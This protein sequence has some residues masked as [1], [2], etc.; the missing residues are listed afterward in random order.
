MHQF[1]DRASGEV[2]DEDLFCDRLIAYLYGRTREQAPALFRALT[3]GRT[4]SLLGFLNYDLPLGAR[5]SSADRLARRLGIDLDECVRPRA[6][7][8]TA[9]RIFERQIRYETV[10]PMDESP[11]EVVSP[12]DSRMF[13]GA[14]EPGSVFF[15]KDKFFS[16]PELLGP[17][18]RDWLAAFKDGDFAVF[19]LTP[20]KYHYNHVPVGGVVR[21]IYTIEG[22]FHSCN[23]TAVI[24]E[25][26]PFS[27]NRRVVTILDTDV[28]GGAGCG[29]V[30][31]VEVVALMIG[32]IVQAYSDHDYDAPQSL[33]PGMFL[34]KGRPKSLYR[35]GSSLDVLIFQKGRVEFCPDLRRHQGRADVTNRFSDW[36]GRS[37]IETDVR[38]RETIAHVRHAGTERSLE[39][40]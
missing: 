28:P 34:R 7:Y 36:L 18:K 13:V 29:L 23:P 2:R 24:H 8:T 26:T 21:D 33:R 37:W 11:T 30:A 19:R 9:R 35:P 32:Q 40:A 14:L 12:A 38:V 15:I 10:R 16:F 17:E 6:E 20:D 31:M 5:L 1:V 25:V 3:S 39:A 27:R 22:A 4:S